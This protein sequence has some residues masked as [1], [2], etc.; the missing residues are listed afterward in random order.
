M[1]SQLHL[2]SGASVWLKHIKRNWKNTGEQSQIEPY[3]ISVAKYPTYIIQETI[4]EM[5]LFLQK[6]HNSQPSL[7]CSLSGPTNIIASENMFSKMAGIS[8]PF[9]NMHPTTEVQVLDLKSSVYIP[10]CWYG[11]S[12]KFS[13]YRNLVCVVN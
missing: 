11:L 10:A 8:K 13:S 12:L 5:P 1:P 3:K 6:W 7:S 2:F 4:I 9:E